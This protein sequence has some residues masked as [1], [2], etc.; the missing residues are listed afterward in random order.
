MPIASRHGWEG[1]E[2][3][4]YAHLLEFKMLQMALDHFFKEVVDG[5]VPLGPPSPE[6][7][8]WDRAIQDELVTRYSEPWC[9]IF[10]A[11]ADIRERLQDAGIPLDR[12]RISDG[13]RVTVTNGRRADSWTVGE[14]EEPVTWERGARGES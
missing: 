1:E 11:L 2:Y 5:N 9:L 13:L 7:E 10:E 6:D 14:N 4:F 8:W 12:V 3:S